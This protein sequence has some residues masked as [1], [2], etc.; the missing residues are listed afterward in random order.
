MA[1]FAPGVPTR[2]YAGRPSDFV[3]LQTPVIIHTHTNT[4][5][6]IYTHPG[7]YSS[8]WDCLVKILRAQGVLG[9]YRGMAPRFVR[10]CLEI[11]LHFTL[12]E[13]I[14]RQLDRVW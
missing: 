11:G 6:I 5:P 10:V 14:S 4:P 12:F 9:L 8:S 13:R 7:G 1:S 3:F 2:A